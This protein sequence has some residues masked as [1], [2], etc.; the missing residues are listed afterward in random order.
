MHLSFDAS[1]RSLRHF[2]NAFVHLA[3]NP[4]ALRV[5]PAR[6]RSTLSQR[7]WLQTQI[8]LD[9][10]ANDE[11]TS[12]SKSGR[13]HATYLGC[14]HD[15]PSKGCMRWREVDVTDSAVLNVPHA[16]IITNPHGQAPHC[17]RAESEGCDSTL[18]NMLVAQELSCELAA[19]NC[20]R[21]A[22]SDI[23]ITK[24]AQFSPEE[25]N[26]NK[27][28]LLR[29][30]TTGSSAVMSAGKVLM[31]LLLDASARSLR[32]FWNAFVHLAGNPVAKRV[33]PARRRSTL[34][35]RLL[36]ANPNLAR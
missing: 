8:R 5:L 22:S 25:P 26:C 6:R 34:R 4:V 30:I 29:A 31:L 11:A 35:L 17:Y 15:G 21:C 24:C 16:L 12:S 7:R 33:I 2:W 32:H 10:R 19:R 9:D 27:T 18:H 3:G 14:L 1:A 28:Y 36:A 23:V 20:D 13:A